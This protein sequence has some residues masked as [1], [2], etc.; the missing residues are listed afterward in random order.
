MNK[1]G[2]EWEGVRGK[3]DKEQEEEERK[4][5]QWGTREAEKIVRGARWG[6]VECGYGRSRT[7]PRTGP[8]RPDGAHEKKNDKNDEYPAARSHQ[9][10]KIAAVAAATIHY[11]ARVCMLVLAGPINFRHFITPTCATYLRLPRLFV[12]PTPDFFRREK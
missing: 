11:R 6:K 10:P 12:E 4:G 7:S 5:S 3:R 9:I 1:S 8:A 2:E